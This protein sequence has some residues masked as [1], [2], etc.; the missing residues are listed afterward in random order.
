[1][2][3][4]VVIPVYREDAITTLI[5]DLLSRPDLGRTEILVVDGAPGHD[6]LQRITR[7]D[8]IGLTSQP[9]RAIQQNAGAAA[10]TGEI[11]LFL[12]AD[13]RLP[14]NAF[15][16]IRHVMR[17]SS[18]SGGAFRL[19][20]AS[21]SY[22]LRLIARAANLRTAL[23]RVPYGDQAIFLRRSVF[24]DLGGF[25]SIPIMEDLDLMTRLRRS[26]RSITLLHAPI[27]TSARRH[28]R[29]GLLL[30]TLR[31]LTLRLLYHC[32]VA[33]ENLTRLYRR[34]GD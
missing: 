26:G 10:A 8:I 11:L 22:G 9:G 18:L 2:N 23:T 16:L 21:T 12:H 31:N 34:H 29:E 1:M 7:P 33:P 13:T 14:R 20:Y 6:T 27:R 24:T 19:D 30:C 5:H 28:E 25:A 3:I 17:D 4:S 15:D 32:G